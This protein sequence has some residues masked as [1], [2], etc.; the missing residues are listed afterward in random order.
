MEAAITLP[1]G[2][3]MGLFADVGGALFRRA[4]WLIGDEAVA[5][6]VAEELFVRFVVHG[7]A[8]GMSARDRWN[9]IYR[10]VTSHCLRQLSDDAIPGASAAAHGAQTDEQLPAMGALRRMDEATQGIVVL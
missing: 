4:A 7:N 5:V 2:P 1:A 10:V 3:T 8:Q 6:R 9:W